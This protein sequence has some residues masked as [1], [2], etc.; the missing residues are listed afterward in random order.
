MNTPFLNIVRAVDWM[1][2]PWLTLI[3]KTNLFLMFWSKF[4][5]LFK[6]LHQKRLFYSYLILR[7]SCDEGC[8]L[9]IYLF[10]FINYFLQMSRHKRNTAH[11]T[12]NDIQQRPPPI[13]LN[14]CMDWTSAFIELTLVP[15]SSSSLV[16]L[17]FKKKIYI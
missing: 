6:V 14:I 16:G 3:I 13:C 2:W 8:W 7:W 1:T 15:L 4:L 12:C 17:S 11:T 9:F 10:Y 5:I